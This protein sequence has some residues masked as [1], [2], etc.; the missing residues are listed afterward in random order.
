[1]LLNPVA[2]TQGLGRNLG[3]KNEENGT[4]SAVRLFLNRRPGVPRALRVGTPGYCYSSASRTRPGA[5]MARLGL[6]WVGLNVF[7]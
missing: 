6:P 7:I 5:P 1:V 4:A 3:R 2:S